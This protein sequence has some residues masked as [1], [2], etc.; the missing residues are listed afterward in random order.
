MEGGSA[1]WHAY[2]REDRNAPGAPSTEQ[3]E[4]EGSSG[5]DEKVDEEPTIPS[6]RAKGSSR[7]GSGDGQDPVAL[8]TTPP[9]ERQTSSPR[10]DVPP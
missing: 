6:L 8:Q 4:S 7:L 10:G 3:V 1:S 2:R 5:E 9:P